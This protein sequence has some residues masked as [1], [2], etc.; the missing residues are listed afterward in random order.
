M[1][2]LPMARIS[3][4]L[5]IL[6]FPIACHKADQPVPD[7][8]LPTRDAN[9]ALGNPSNASTS[10]EN[11]YLIE[12]PSYTL[13]YNRSTGIANWC[14]WHLSKAWKGSVNRYN[15][16][17]IPD[18]TLPTG[19]YQVRHDDYTL[20]GFDRGHLC[21]SDDRD[22]TAE[23]NRTT[24]FMT[25]IVPQAPRLNR[26]NWN[27]LEGYTRKL[28]GDGNETYIIAGTFGKGGTG[29]NGTA[30]TIAGG[31]V[32]V[33]AA[34]WKVIVVLPVGSDDL[35]RISAQTR[36]IAVWIPNSNAAGDQPW[37]NYR[38]SVDEIESQTGYDLLSNV[39]DA[40]ES[41]IEKQADKVTVQEVEMYPVW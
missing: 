14:S 40:I 5:I 19:W 39:P 6:L 34:M 27:Q 41:V 21:P 23:E 8:S 37:D 12:R 35:S 32:T 18:Q 4:Y 1:F 33:P 22:S 38:V 24:F 28:I 20:S 13:S 31:K 3:L 15:G 2:S 11:N 36:V 29:D 26:E 10:Q 7:S 30:S 9:M 16:I 25:N 17:F